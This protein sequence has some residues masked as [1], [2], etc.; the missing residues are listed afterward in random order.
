MEKKIQS[1]EFEC[2]K[3]PILA[4][5]TRK[6]GIYFHF[7]CQQVVL[8]GGPE[9]PLAETLISQPNSLHPRPGHTDCCC[10]NK[11]NFFSAY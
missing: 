2:L 5:M 9:P 11:N 4:K 8:E 7:L 3:W 1:F 6:S 10:E